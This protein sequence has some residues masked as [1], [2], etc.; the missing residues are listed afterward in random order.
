MYAVRMPYVEGRVIMPRTV[1]DT[2]LSTRSSRL[3]L[4]MR[5]EPYWRSL[6][7]GLA[8][9]YRRGSTG[10]TWVARHY[11]KG[12]GRT[13]EA[14][15]TAD[16]VADADGVYVLSFDHA[17]AKAREWLAGRAAAD[18]PSAAKAGPYTVKDAC[19]DYVKDYERRGGRGLRTV[20]SAINAHITPSL[21][22][23]EVRKLTTPRLR[24]WLHNLADGPAL[25]RTKAGNARK[26]RAPPK[27]ADGKR[28]R[29]AAA[30]RI[31]NV[32]QAALNFAWREGKAPSAEAWRKVSR[33]R[34]VD[35]PLIRYLTNAECVRLVNACAADFRKLVQAALLTGARYSELIGLRCDDFNADSGTLTARITK[36]GK[37][38][39]TVLT[40]EGREFFA[41]VAAG[42]PRT[43]AMFLRENGSPWQP[44]DKTRP[45]AAACEAAKIVPA[46]GF[47]VLRHTHGSTLAM[48]GVPLP[49]IAKQL[50]HADTRMTE[51]HYAHLA[52]SYVADIIRANFPTL[53]IV[54]KGNVAALNPSSRQNAKTVG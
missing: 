16:D 32:L 15:G 10:G 46:I 1:A 27:D 45:I 8:V 49:V 14:L 36:S 5:R 31:F 19:E 7:Q 3:R 54:E 9:G 50:G 30:N 23:V 53:G 21:G 47:H 42:R 13:Y 43:Q 52:P 25:L 12:T 4:K 11:V 39:H 38:H 51:R 35:A 41:A 29:K 37:P 40:D 6:L 44:S 34:D 33:F 28:R 2:K 22:T 17:Q 24:A 18:D 48:R 20:R 26:H